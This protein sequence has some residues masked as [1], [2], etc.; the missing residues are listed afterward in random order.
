MWL[1][2]RFSIRSAVDVQSYAGIFETVRKSFQDSTDAEVDSGY[3]DA[4][5]DVDVAE[6]HTRVETAKRWLWKR[7]SELELIHCSLYDE[8]D[9]A[10]V[11]EGLQSTAQL[12]ADLDSYMMESQELPQTKA[13]SCPS[14]WLFD[15]GALRIHEPGASE[16]CQTGND[17]EIGNQ[18]W[19]AGVALARLIDKR[20]LFQPTPLS[21]ILELGCGTALT[22]IVAAKCLPDTEIVASDWHPSILATATQN[23]VENNVAAQVSVCR[24]DWRNL[25]D[26]DWSSVGIVDALMAADVIYDV[27][28]AALIPKVMRHIVDQ[29]AAIRTKM[30][31]IVILNRVRPQFEQAIETFENNMRLQGFVGSWVWADSIADVFGHD[32]RLESRRYRLYRYKLQIETRVE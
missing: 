3:G 8:D 25:V 20:V 12:L 19:N 31:D 30:I 13:G 29:H 23:V 18:V 15:C 17:I 22:A 4:D 10:L 24:L 2:P 6:R 9:L 16:S 32:A 27:E 21:T 28:H 1:P 5:P 7:M 26:F 14:E 11:V